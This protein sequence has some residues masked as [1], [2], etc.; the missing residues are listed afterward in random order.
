[1]RHRDT[2]EPVADFHCS[3][4]VRDK[5][6]LRSV[7]E[8]LDVFA[9]AEYVD[10][11]ECCLNL[12]ENTEGRGIDLKYREEKRNCDEGLLATRKK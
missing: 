6:K 7:T 4:A 2:V 5:Y 1:M 9:K 12:V 8:A 10:L 3:S 11:V